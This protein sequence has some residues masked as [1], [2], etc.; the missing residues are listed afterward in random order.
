MRTRY[1]TKAG[2]VY[3]VRKCS[4]EEVAGHYQKLKGSTEDVSEEE[5]L[6]RMTKAAEQKCA[7]VVIKDGVE[8]AH[9]YVYKVINMW[10]TASIWSKDTIGALLMFKALHDELGNITIR[11]IP[12]ADRPMELK[13]LATK[14]SIRLFHAGNEYVRISTKEME[15]KYR[16]MYEVLG[17]QKCQEQKK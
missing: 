4:I 17:V 10:L 2:G 3:E 8:V 11:H 12:H 6:G 1:K 13:S 14:K 15:T 16:R 7:W 9:I 5:Y